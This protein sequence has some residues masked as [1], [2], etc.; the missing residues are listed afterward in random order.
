MINVEGTSVAAWASEAPILFIELG[1]VS[2][3]RIRADD[4][5]DMI[6]M[7]ARDMGSLLSH[8]KGGELEGLKQNTNF[9]GGQTWRGLLQVAQ[10]ANESAYC[11][12]CSNHEGFV[13]NHN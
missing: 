6:I 5:D 4:E 3:H 11:G 9:V 13:Y 7:L 1:D 12:G 8:L 10:K 2:L